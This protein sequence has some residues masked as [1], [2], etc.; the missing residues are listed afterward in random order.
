[1]EVTESYLL[2]RLANPADDADVSSI[3]SLQ[4]GS[5]KKREAGDG[6]VEKPNKIGL[7]ANTRFIES[8]HG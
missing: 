6:E 1:M 5:E 2:G 4:V 3:Y 7:F 8:W